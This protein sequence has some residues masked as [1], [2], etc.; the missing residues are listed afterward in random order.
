MPID[1]ATRVRIVA[2]AVRTGRI[3]RA[4]LAAGEGETVGPP[5]SLKCSGC[6][7]PLHEARPSADRA[8]AVARAVLG[9]PPKHKKS[10]IR[11]K[12]AKVEAAA[13]RVLDFAV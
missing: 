11:K 8:G 4:M 5:T 3:G 10:R 2:E 1:E 12:W 6:R 13:R 9:D 7:G